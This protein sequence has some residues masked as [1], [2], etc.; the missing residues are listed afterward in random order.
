MARK[1]AKPA[2]WI[3]GL[4]TLAIIGLIIVK[5]GHR[6]GRIIM[7]Q[8]QDYD[9]LTSQDDVFVLNVHVPKQKPLP[10]TDESI[11]YNLLSQNQASL[12]ENKK[13]P[14]LV[15]CRSGSMS[16]IAAKQLLKM[17]YKTI[18]DL[19]GGVKAYEESHAQVKLSPSEYGFGRVRYGDVAKTEFVL[20]NQTSSAL[21]ITRIS[22]SC[23]CT[24]ATVA[25]R[26]LKPGGST[27]V[28][29]K[30]NP[31]V[32]KDDSDL[33]QLTRTIFIDTDNPNYPRLIAKIT[34]DVYKN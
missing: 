8:S 25:D 22:T 16:R 18:Y 6:P 10:Q 30:F 27:V 31:A 2:A 21:N 3:M 9:N 32:H 24:T 17:G 23:G 1:A 5:A 28:K 15:Y 33:G 14:I 26:Q 4:L 34:A 12:P 7:I 29:V 11:A 13:T 20:A 19:E